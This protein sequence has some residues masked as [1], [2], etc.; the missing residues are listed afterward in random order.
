MLVIYSVFYAWKHLFHWDF[1]DD[2]DKTWHR[3][4]TQSVVVA[5]FS[6]IAFL[7][8]FFPTYTYK[9][10]NRLLGWPEVKNGTVEWHR[11]CWY[12]FL[13]PV[14]FLFTCM[15]I[16]AA[17]SIYLT[18]C[19]QQFQFQ[20]YLFFSFRLPLSVSQPLIAKHH[21]SPTLLL[22]LPYDH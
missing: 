15:L 21:L 7:Y 3:S 14:L 4:K 6:V 16:I 17:A 10:K 12:L 1:Y 20:T 22:C 9:Q 2:I 19:V 8:V 5:M 13:S 18:L 11:V